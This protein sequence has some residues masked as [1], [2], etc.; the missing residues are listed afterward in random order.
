MA[1]WARWKSPGEPEIFDG[2][3]DIIANK[4]RHPRNIVSLWTDEEL[5]AIGLMKLIEANVPNGQVVTGRSYKEVAGEIREQLE[6]EPA[7]PPPPPRFENA[8]QAI[9]A[10]DWPAA[11]A[12]LAQALRDM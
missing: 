8:A 2:G 5:E 1:K 7:P 10:A 6:T 12:I 3:R 11:R 4:V 9:E